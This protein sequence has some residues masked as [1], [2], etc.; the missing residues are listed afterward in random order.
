[1]E[2]ALKSRLESKSELEIAL[3]IA[4]GMRR[5]HVHGAIRRGM[6]SAKVFLNGP[7]E[8]SAGDSS[9]SRTVDSFDLTGGRGTPLHAAPEGIHERDVNITN[10]WTVFSFASLVH[11]FLSD[12]ENCADKRNRLRLKAPSS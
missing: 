11:S 5:L 3:G 2:L 4:A 1:M 6:K 8:V 10:K 12:N 9:I 7:F